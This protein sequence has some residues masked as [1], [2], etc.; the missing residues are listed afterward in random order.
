MQAQPLVMLAHKSLA[1]DRANA[2]F[3]AGLTLNHGDVQTVAATE[4]DRHHERVH[5]GHCA[6]DF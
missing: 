2:N 6:L 1:N 5:Q 4:G 3:L